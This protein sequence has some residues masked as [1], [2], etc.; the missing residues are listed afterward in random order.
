L[1]DGFGNYFIVAAKPRYAIRFCP[2]SKKYI[3]TWK[4]GKKE[5]YGSCYNK[6][7]KLIYQGLFKN[8]KPK[9]KYPGI[10][11]PKQ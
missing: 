10:H 8:D 11:K 3:G 2:R 6:K 9:Q 4:E 5:G 7:G 1:K